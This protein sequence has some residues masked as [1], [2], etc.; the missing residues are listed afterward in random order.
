M[1]PWI[2][3]LL[4]GVLM[5]LPHLMV[6]SGGRVFY[7]DQPGF[8]FADKFDD[9]GIWQEGYHIWTCDG[10]EVRRQTFTSEWEDLGLPGPQPFSCTPRVLQTSGCSPWDG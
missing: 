4:G 6:E 10:E 8:Y 7:C 9:H 5:V 1:S 3:F 2:G